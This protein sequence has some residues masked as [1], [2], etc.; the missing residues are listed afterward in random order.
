MASSKEKPI[1]ADNI[2][3]F[4]ERTERDSLLGP[5]P[6]AP[7]DT[8]RL[9]YCIFFLHGVGHLLPW[10]F[11]I[12][13]QLYFQAKF[14]CPHGNN[15]ACYGFNSTFENWFSV[16]SMVPI[17]VMSAANVWLQSRFHYRLRMVA[18]LV[19][20][21]TLFLITTALVGVPVASWTDGFFAVT[22]LTV[23]LMNAASSIFQS[24]TFG[25]AGV[26]PNNYTSSVMSG[27]AVAG[28]FA[29]VASLLSQVISSSV[30]G[31]QSPQTI[32]DSAYGY[33]SLAC[34]V[35][36]VCLVSV[37]F[38][39]KMPFVHHY[40]EHTSVQ[41]LRQKQ[42]KVVD[43]SLQARVIVRPSY[44]AIMRKVCL[45]RWGILTCV[46]NVA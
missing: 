27:Q 3:P 29:A 31:E 2:L 15:T 45:F 46:E 13:A 41:V 11:F 9:A 32:A 16:A 44:L 42:Q 18:S 37:F 39:S 26:L 38:L 1:H 36:V 6:S 33:F 22:L 43:A 35:L 24:S 30:Q 5:R 23:F 21:L 8:C 17:F 4:K 34:L 12:T 14:T 28:V 19:V 10:N 25:F 20:M 40:L 7:A